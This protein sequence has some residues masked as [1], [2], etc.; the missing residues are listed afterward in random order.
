MQ[1]YRQAKPHIGSDCPDCAFTAPGHQLCQHDGCDDIAEAQHKRHATEQEYTALPEAFQ[2]IDGICH[3]TVFTCG[4]HEVDEFCNHTPAGAEPVSCPKCNAEPGNPCTKANGKTRRI[5]HPVR[6][7][8]QPMIPVETC[9]HVHREDCGGQDLCQ[10]SPDDVAP[11]RPKRIVQPPPKPGP[12]PIHM[13][14]HGTVGDLL[15]EHGID[16]DRIMTIDVRPTNGGHALHAVMA[17]LDNHGHHK[18][19]DHGHLLTEEVD[20]PFELCGP[21]SPAKI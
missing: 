13:P 9:N 11:E 17:V 14:T 19:D 5:D 3:Q 7:G 12:A 21:T 2:P 15:V 6:A 1:P 18:F 16:M 8:A 4:D 10:C 20:V